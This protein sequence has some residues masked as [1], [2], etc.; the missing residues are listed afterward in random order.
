[1]FQGRGPVAIYPLA[2]ET[3]L[4]LREIQ[5][6]LACPEENGVLPAF[7]HLH[8]NA[9]PPSVI[10]VGVHFLVEVEGPAALPGRPRPDLNDVDCLLADH[11][12]LV[13][14]AAEAIVVAANLNL[15]PI[16]EV[17]VQQ[18]FKAVFHSTSVGKGYLGFSEE[19]K[20]FKLLDIY[21]LMRNRK[22]RRFLMRSDQFWRRRSFLEKATRTILE[23]RP[24][25]V[26]FSGTER[27]DHNSSRE[28]GDQFWS[29]SLE[30]GKDGQTRGDELWSPS[31]P[32]LELGK[33]DQTSSGETTSYSHLL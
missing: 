33:G 8:Y 16:R 12:A 20:K 2:V 22:V 17:G 4:R 30:L 13:P 19:M 14:R 5:L 23:R 10:A 18:C 28:A 25:L 31:P 9:L 15:R 11:L 26:A 6:F 7:Q 1:M 21:T 3:E 27:S 29:P 24:V 32:S